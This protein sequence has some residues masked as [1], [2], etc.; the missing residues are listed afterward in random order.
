MA[1]EIVM[2]RQ[3][4]GRPVDVWSLGVLLYAMLC[5]MFPFTAKSYPELYKTIVRAH[6]R[7]P[8]FMVTVFCLCTLMPWEIYRSQS[9]NSCT[10]IVCC[11]RIVTCCK[12]SFATHA[13][14]RRQKACNG[15]PNSQ[16]LLVLHT[17][18]SPN[19]T[20]E[21]ASRALF[22]SFQPRGRGYVPRSYC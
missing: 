15:C 3:Y 17:H 13:A 18:P 7:L 22:A 19:Q 8:D 2:R 4:E 5:G 12:R 10:C 20:I 9:S 16:A 6:L 14:S 21:V 1:P 11:Q